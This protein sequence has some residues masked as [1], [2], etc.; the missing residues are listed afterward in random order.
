MNS[1][2]KIAFIILLF[3]ISSSG[4][5]Q[6]HRQ[7]SNWFC[8]KYSINKKD[9][10]SNI[11]VGESQIVNLSNIDSNNYWL[12]EDMSLNN[13]KRQRLLH[14]VLLDSGYV[15]V[16]I[17]NLKNGKLNNAVTSFKQIK[18][19]NYQKVNLSKLIFYYNRPSRGFEILNDSNRIFYLDKYNLTV[20]CCNDFSTFYFDVLNIKSELLF[21]KS[22]D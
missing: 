2:K 5:A 12:V 6:N 18:L 15:C 20:K 1:G 8:G 13:I 11:S 21:K 16:D 10:T 7:F 9:N 3:L 4:I 22:N 19:D 17:Y 14:V